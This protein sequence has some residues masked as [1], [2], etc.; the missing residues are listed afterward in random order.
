MTSAASTILVLSVKMDELMTPSSRKVFKYVISLWASTTR[1]LGPFT[2]SSWSPKCNT[3]LATWFIFP[4][5]SLKVSSA[6]L[7]LSCKPWI[8]LLNTV[9]SSRTA[10]SKRWHFFCCLSWSKVRSLLVIK[11]IVNII[12]NKNV[13]IYEK[14]V[15]FYLMAC[16][17]ESWSNMGLKSS[18]PSFFVSAIVL[19]AK[20]STNSSASNGSCNISYMYY[21]KQ[22]HFIII[23]K[24]I[25]NGL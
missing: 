3:L 7:L 22:W 23:N 1:A 24:L 2:L 14:K 8:S 4:S 15:K 18:S 12:M 16:R 25:Q 20:R 19:H 6:T 10:A 13:E 5:S 17:K 21:L 9:S 11:Y